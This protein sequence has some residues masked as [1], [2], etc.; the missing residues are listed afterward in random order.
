MSQLSLLIL[1]ILLTPKIHVHTTLITG[2]RCHLDVWTARTSKRSRA[3][4]L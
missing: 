4:Y 1:V 3:N 2:Y